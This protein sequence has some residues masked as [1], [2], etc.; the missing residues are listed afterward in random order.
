MSKTHLKS[1]V[2]PKTWVLHRKEN[3]FVTKPCAGPHSLKFSLPLSFL[4]KGTG[5]AS[6]TRE[7]K[8]ILNT[9]IVL[10][11]GRRIKNS[12]FP[13]GLMDTV[14][15]KDVASFFRIVLD[16]KGRLR[17]LPIKES[18]TALKLCRVNN[19]TVIKNN[20]LQLNLFDGKNILTE[21]KDI[22]TGDSVLLELPGQK[23]KNVL[24]F[25]KGM[26]ALLIGGSH[27]G[28]FG[29]IEDIQGRVV[30]MISDKTKFNTRKEFVFVVGKDKE[31]IQ[32]K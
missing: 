17:V 18:E 29:V 9:K 28:G 31:V 23:I 10:A 30:T 4:L 20:K 1:I 12:K 25:E 3:K 26:Y 16:E 22:R 15:I 8:K 24:R 27:M 32:L 14:S 11:D 6:T 21:K 2:A 5:F 19:K 13:V 7:A